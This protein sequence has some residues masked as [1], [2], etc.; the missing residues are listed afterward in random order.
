MTDPVLAADGH[1][2]DRATILEWFARKGAISMSTGGM[3]PEGSTSL[4]PN[5][6]ARDLI[7]RCSNLPSQIHV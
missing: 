7:A 1:T 3:M 4:V 5:K 6:V 2:Y